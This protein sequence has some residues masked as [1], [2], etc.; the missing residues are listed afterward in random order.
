MRHAQGGLSLPD[1]PRGVHTP[2]TCYPGLLLQTLLRKAPANKHVARLVERLLAAAPAPATTL[3][4]RLRG[5]IVASVA[6]ANSMRRRLTRS[7]AAQA[8]PEVAFRTMVLQVRRDGALIG[9]RVQRKPTDSSAGM[10]RTCRNVLRPSAAAASSIHVALPVKRSPGTRP[11]CLPV[12]ACPHHTSARRWASSASAPR[13]L[14]SCWPSC[15]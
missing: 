4:S 1:F 2:C 9:L 11:A 13:S 10:R 5:S 8:H 7:F 12:C 3:G 14:R 6:A 15:A